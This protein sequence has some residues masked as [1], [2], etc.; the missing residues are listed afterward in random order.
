MYV[1]D[2]AQAIYSQIDGLFNVMT[3]TIER[4]F[5][6]FDKKIERL[7]QSN[8]DDHSPDLFRE[9]DEIFEST[10]IYGNEDLLRIRAKDY[11]DYGRLLLRKLYSKKELAERILPPG[12]QRYTR[13]PLDNDRFEYLHRAMATKFR[14]SSLHYGQFYTKL[15]RPKLADF[16]IDERK[17]Q[18]KEAQMMMIT[19]SNDN[20]IS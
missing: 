20:S 8:F 1:L 2:A 3:R 10:V 4:R 19:D 16:L 14:L 11:G 13:P 15:L 18:N 6:H 12:H 17:R 5:I 9:K 7:A